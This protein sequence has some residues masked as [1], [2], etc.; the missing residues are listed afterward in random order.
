MFL[1]EDAR[2]SAVIDHHHQT[3]LVTLCPVIGSV[4]VDSEQAPPIGCE[5][6]L[7]AGRDKRCHDITRI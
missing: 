7:A 1:R 3:N 2:D 5:P 4:L 6:Q